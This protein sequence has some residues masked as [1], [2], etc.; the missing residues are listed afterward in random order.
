LGIKNFDPLT[1]SSLCL[2]TSA[3]IYHLEDVAPYS[4]FTEQLFRAVAS[5]T[6]R[7]VISSLSVAEIFTKP[8]AQQD[9]AAISIIEN[10]L[11]TFPGLEIIPTSYSIARKAA[12]LRAKYRL[13]TPD[14]II[15]ATALITNCEG[16]VSNDLQWKRLSNE[17]IKVVILD[18]QI[19]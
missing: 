4:D 5:S 3:L 15:V 9:Q 18:E 1:S 13:K 11:L 12:E 10:F 17:K 2:D 6:T 16:L 7:C 14:A 8:F 19:K